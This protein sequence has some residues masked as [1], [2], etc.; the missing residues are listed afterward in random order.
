M[1]DDSQIEKGEGSPEGKVESSKA[2]LSDDQVRNIIFNETR[3]LSG[4]AIGDV[5]RSIAHIVINGDEALG[6]D[7]P[8]TASSELPSRISTEEQ[9][10]LD[11]IAE[12]VAGV[13]AERADGIDPTNGARY[14]G[15]RDVNNFRTGLEGLAGP[16]V[17]RFGTQTPIRSGVSGPLNN[18]FP[19]TALGPS[20][21]YFVPFE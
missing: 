6:A 2:V 9:T 7:R 13:R 21:I 16:G 3:S 17:K 8:E 20:G 4:P 19:T 10:V 18:S 15:F 1:H 5:R 14:F 12:V 11:S